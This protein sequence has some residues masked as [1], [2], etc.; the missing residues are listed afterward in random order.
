MPGCGERE[1]ERETPES[2]SLI[3]VGHLKTSTMTPLSPDS[4]HRKCRFRSNPEFQRS[5]RPRYDPPVNVYEL[6]QG[7]RKRMTGAQ[8]SASPGGH[9]GPNPDPLS[10]A[11][12]AA[13]TQN[14]GR[15]HQPLNQA[16]LRPEAASLCTFTANMKAGQHRAAGSWLWPQEQA[17]Q[18]AGATKLP[19]GYI[20]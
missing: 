8:T 6:N 17:A 14:A 12:I 11:A 10:A 13:S 1:R 15:P 20:I 16:A 4:V 3:T 19:K 5:G 7:S 2:D 9:T 18:A